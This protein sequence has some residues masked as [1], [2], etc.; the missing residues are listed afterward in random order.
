MDFIK[1]KMS[2][3]GTSLVH[4]KVVIRLQQLEFIHDSTGEVWVQFK[5]GKHREQ[6]AHYPVTAAGFG[7]QTATL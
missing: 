1:R 2:R 6:T 7:R 3:M 4:H 5:R